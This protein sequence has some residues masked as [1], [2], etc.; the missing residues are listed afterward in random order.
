[1]KKIQSFSIS[2]LRVEE[3]FGFLKLVA[4]ETSYLAPEEDDKPEEL[5]VRSTTSTPLTNAVDVFKVA[6]DNFDAALKD[7]ASLSSTTLAA[8]ADTVRDNA[9]RGANNYLKAMMA[10][11]TSDVAQ[12]ASEMRAL[13]D[14]YGDPT[15]LSQTEESGILH[16]L[17]QD[18]NA[19]DSSQR[20]AVNFDVWLTNLESSEAAFLSAVSLRTEEEATRQVGI[21]KEA[22]VAAD[23]SYRSLVELVNA[24]VVVNGEDEYATFIDH[25]NTLID[26]QKAI[27]KTRS[28]NAK[29]SKEE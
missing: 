20:A 16:N 28:T 5:L 25:V 24:L 13:F 10:H 18:L 29:K 8:E 22:R 3:D 23:K 1:M 15:S 11:P 21:V 19:V 12:A 7:S 4:A 6:V 17:L 26:R 27:L 14:K 9:W 2:S